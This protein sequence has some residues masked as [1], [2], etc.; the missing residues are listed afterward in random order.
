MIKRSFDP[1][2]LRQ[3][4]AMHPDDQS[5]VD[6]EAWIDNERNVMYLDDSGSV[7]LLTFEYPGLYNAHWFFRVRG[8]N[9][10]DL[11]RKMLHK[12][13]QETDM[14]AVRGLTPMSLPNVR[15][16]ARRVGLTSYGQITCSDGKDY[17]LFCMTKDE[18]YNNKN[19][20]RQ[21]LKL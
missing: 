17:E 8:K 13:F 11:A 16:A 14:Q 5:E 20:K 4:L 1:E 7:G 18:F 10:Y 3:A 19:T 6:A 21:G 2:L 12:G 15:M 9:A